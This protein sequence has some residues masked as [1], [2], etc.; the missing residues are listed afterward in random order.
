M[1]AIVDGKCLR[2]QTIVY[3]RIHWMSIIADKLSIIVYIRCLRSYTLN[4]YDRRHFHR[5]VYDRRQL[6]SIFVSVLSTIVD[7]ERLPSYTFGVY[8]RRQFVYDR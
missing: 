2:P 3:H 8:H 7:M 1:S 6:M 4:V 5:T